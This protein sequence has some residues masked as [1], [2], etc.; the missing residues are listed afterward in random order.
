MPE[1]IDKPGHPRRPS[2]GGSRRAGLI[3]ALF[4]IL[5]GIGWSTGAI[6][7]DAWPL[8]LQQQMTRVSEVGWRLADAADALCRDRAAPI[9]A[10]LDY[11]RAYA[12]ADRPQAAATLA[13]GDAPKVFSVIPQS[14][15]AYGGLRA[16]DEVI[17]V[18]AREWRTIAAAL[19]TPDLLADELQALIA[20]LP[21]EEP[22]VL[23]VRREGAETAIPVTRTERCA[24]RFVL[25]TGGGLEA[26]SDSANVAI[27]DKLVAF[28]RN[29]DELAMVLAHELAHVLYQD[30]R[31]MPL[32][33]RRRAEERADLAGALLA[34]CAGYDLGRALALFRRLGERDWLDW[35]GSPTHGGMKR[36]AARLEAVAGAEAACPMTALPATGEARMTA[37]AAGR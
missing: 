30:K 29:D 1:T 12:P 35:L 19:D 20:T 25:K 36:R 24:V 21:L 5:P 34:R 31:A 8:R 11:I 6:A 14:P 4:G 13:L 28:T 33:M 15:A 27:S 23:T 10:E 17:A 3:A 32:R 7:R 26:H 18:N 16:G 37:E 2:G 22:L 9:G